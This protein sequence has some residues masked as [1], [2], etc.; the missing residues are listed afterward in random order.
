MA[1]MEHPDMPKSIAGIQGLNPWNILI[2]NVLFAWFSQRQAQ[3]LVWG[4]P[5]SVAWLLL[6][7]LA[8]IFL[9]S[10]RLFWTREGYETSYP[11]SYIIS[12]HFVNGFKFLLPGL[13]L[14]DGCRTRKRV[15]VA[16]AAVLLLY[17]LLALQVIKWMPLHYAMASGDQLSQRA[18]KIIQNEI[19]YN[20]VTLSMMLGG[21]SWV[22]LGHAGA[23]SETPSPSC[24][25]C[26]SW[27]G[28]RGTGSDGWPDG[29]C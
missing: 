14:F 7:Y 12:E 27:C 9:A 4:M 5:Y 11:T 29:L 6:A 2:L 8:V 13:L 20:R 19:G 3:G 21:A 23:F 18:S 17:I 15:H 26:C 1:V 22:R 25:I 16:M 28:G 24:G 10:L